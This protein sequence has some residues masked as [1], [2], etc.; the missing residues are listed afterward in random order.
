M[1]FSESALMQRKR[2]KECAT[3]KVEEKK[4]E[5]VFAKYFPVKGK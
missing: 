5:K 4:I 1:N 2:Q 3:E